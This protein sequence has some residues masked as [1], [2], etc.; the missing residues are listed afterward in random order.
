[1]QSRGLGT[2]LAGAGLD[3]L[4]FTVLALG[5]TWIM[6][7]NPVSKNPDFP[8]FPLVRTVFR[9]IGA[10][11]L[12]ALT[13]IGMIYMLD[14]DGTFS[15]FIRSTAELIS[16]VYVNS[17]DAAQQS[18]LKH[19]LSPD[20]ITDA[21]KKTALNGGVLA[22]VFF[23]FFFSR[24]AAFLAAR[25]SRRYHKTAGDLIGF[26]A[27]GKTIWLLT[28]CLP[29]ILLCRVV[30][31]KIVEVAAWNLLIICA[32]IFLAQGGGIIIFTLARRPIPGFIRLLGTVMFIILI[33]SP[34]INAA[35]VGLIILLGIAEN[36]LPLRRI[37]KP[38][39]EN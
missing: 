28:I 20:K 35:A 24:Q 15:A 36:W 14:R 34:G 11:I 2:G 32:V 17:A 1:M 8:V 10:S 4:Y 31:I 23:L 19:L 30:S 9:F 5:F 27:P 13:L 38:K 33:F 22:S 3:I 16:S 39:E 25:L 18:I 7:G 6:A 21:L 37:G 12:G 26:Y 29:V